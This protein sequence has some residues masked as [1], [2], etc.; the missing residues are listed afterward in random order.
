[1]NENIPEVA[2]LEDPTPGDLNAR[3]HI[4]DGLSDLEELSNDDECSGKSP[5]YDKPSFK[6]K[7]NCQGCVSY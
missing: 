5:R 1:M 4:D 7:V 2:G 3:A 6:A